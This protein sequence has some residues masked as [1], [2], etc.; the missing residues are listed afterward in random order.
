MEVY[1][2]DQNL[3]GAKAGYKG[4]LVLFVHYVTLES[5]T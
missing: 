3:P 2:T 1:V 4:M 5:V